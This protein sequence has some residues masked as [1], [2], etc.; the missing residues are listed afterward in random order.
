MRNYYRI[1]LGR[2]SVYAQECFEG[3]YIGAN[4]DINQDLS[5]DLPDEWRAFNKKFIPVLI[6]RHPDK[7]KVSA[8]L[9]CGALWRISKGIKKGDIITKFAGKDVD[10]ALT[11]LISQQKVGDEV[12]LDVYRD[13]KTVSLKVKL[14]EAK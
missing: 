2:K 1:M 3:G 11:T 9:A 4:F 7:S 10:T 14:E 12:S 13:G 5:G 8:G 6:A